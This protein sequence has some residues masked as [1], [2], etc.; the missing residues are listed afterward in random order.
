[1]LVDLN[2]QG[3]YSLIEFA[4]G[5]VIISMLVTMGV[6]SFSNWIQNSHIRT[7][8]EDIQNGLQLARAEAVRRNVP[9]N[10]Q[11]TTTVDGSCA[12]AADSSN[13][14]ISL[15]DPTGACADS[16]SDTVAPRIIQIRAASEGSVNALVAAGQS[17]ITFNSLGRVTPVPAANISFDISNPS[18]GN[19]IEAGGT[20][21]CLRVLVSTLGQ[22]RMCDPT[23]ASSTT[24]GC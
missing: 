1:M 11:T 23:L 17:S 5:L 8:A 20:V 16:P 19:C 10:F 9:V 22:V 4:I 13:W 3:G 15:D 21:R 6:P 7:A 14:V 2:R 18:A 12:L 24:Q